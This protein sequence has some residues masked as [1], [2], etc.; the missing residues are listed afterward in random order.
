MATLLRKQQKESS[1]RADSQ[2][3]GHLKSILVEGD[4]TGELSCQERFPRRG[5]AT[6][7]RESKE[8]T[9]TRSDLK[10]TRRTI[11]DNAQPNS[12][13]GT[14]YRDSQASGVKNR[15][16]KQRGSVQTAPRSNVNCQ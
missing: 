9:A 11:T 15:F 6:E 4:Q 13:K 12:P 10:S 8:E 16:F 3:R 5:N 2:K 7:L 14:E 1:A